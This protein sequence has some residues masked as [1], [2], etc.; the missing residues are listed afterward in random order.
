MCLH[1]F[2]DNSLSISIWK[3][4]KITN[5]MFYKLFF[6]HSKSRQTNYFKNKAPG[7]AAI[8][9]SEN[10]CFMAKQQIFTVKAFIIQKRF[11]SIIN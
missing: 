1:A 2:F 11:K 8:P 3:R 5:L 6:K 10:S 4:A 9:D 7:S